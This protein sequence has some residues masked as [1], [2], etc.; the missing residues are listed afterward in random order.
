MLKRG[1]WFTIMVRRRPSDG[2]VSRNMVQ[3]TALKLGR[4]ETAFDDELDHPDDLADWLEDLAAQV[5]S[6]RRRR[7]G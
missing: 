1:E 7:T 6:S 4:T 5:R 2:K 3:G